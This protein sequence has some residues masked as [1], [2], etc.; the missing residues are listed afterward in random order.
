M[1]SPRP[2]RAIQ[3]YARRSES[4]FSR[5]NKEWR[6]RWVVRNF[7][8]NQRVRVFA[9][10][11]RSETRDPPDV[12]Y[13]AAAFEVKVIYD[14]GRRPDQEYKLAYRRALAAQSASEL[15]EH[16]SPKTMSLHDLV[17]VVRTEAA[18]YENAYGP[19]EKRMLDLLF[20]V[21]FTTVHG[22]N[23]IDAPIPTGSLYGYR[24]VSFTHGVAS[25]V[26]G[27]TDKAPPFI[28]AHAGQ[29]VTRRATNGAI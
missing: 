24:S 8:E 18:R 6:E 12:R 9:F 15:L 5:E 1:A 13:K 23:E 28:R 20:Y 27:C 7:L 29:L 17:A 25:M 3:V 10:Q 19:S 26:L 2:L 14:P 16:Y 11:I 4:L 22:I 21:N